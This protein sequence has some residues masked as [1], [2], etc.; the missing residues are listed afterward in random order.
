MLDKLSVEDI[1]SL[2]SSNILTTILIWRTRLEPYK[3]IRSENCTALQFSY[4]IE[5]SA[6][7]A[8]S[9]RRRI[10]Q[11]YNSH[12]WLKRQPWKP[13]VQFSYGERGLSYTSCEE[14]LHRSTILICARE[15]SSLSKENTMSL[16]SNWRKSQVQKTKEE[17]CCL[18]SGQPLQVP[19][20]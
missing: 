7:E 1:S 15:T 8:W 11:N 20:K 13:E 14:E 16:K 5:T 18:N 17:I 9:S 19:K 2:L 10:A 3:P 6:I 12:M 4:E